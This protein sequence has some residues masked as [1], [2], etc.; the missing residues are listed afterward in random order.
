[1]VEKDSNRKASQSQGEE[2]RKNNK[3]TKSK[4]KA[5]YQPDKGKDKP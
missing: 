3:A 4:E 5:G 2:A 1:M